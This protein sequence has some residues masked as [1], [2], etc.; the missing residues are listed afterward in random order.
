MGV[1]THL[2]DYMAVFY[3]ATIALIIPKLN[4]LFSLKLTLTPPLVISEGKL[5]AALD[6]IDSAIKYLL[7]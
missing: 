6:I 3:C 4:I 1:N 2:T 5:N 7:V